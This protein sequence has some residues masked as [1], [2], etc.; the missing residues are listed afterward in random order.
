MLSSLKHY[1]IYNK[2][3]TLSETFTNNL[4]CDNRKKIVAQPPYIFVEVP[5]A[6]FPDQVGEPELVILVAVSLVWVKPEPIL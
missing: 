5:V 3:W 6:T 4:A 1:T 2:Y